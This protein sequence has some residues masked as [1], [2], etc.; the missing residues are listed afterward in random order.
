MKI[1]NKEL[2]RFSKQIILKNIGL[3]GQKKIFASKVLIIGVGGLG[4]PLAL[5]LA[6]SGVGNIGIIDHDKIELTNLNRQVLF[7]SKDLGKYKVDQARKVIKNIN[8][9]IK[10]TSYRKLVTKKNINSILKNYDIICDGTDNFKSRYLINDYC[11]KKKKILISAAISKYD[12]HIF[13]FNFKKKTPCFRCFMPQIPKNQY[14]CDTEGIISTLAGIMGT[15]QAN[16]VIK[17]I[18][19]SKSDLSGKM[20][21]FNSLSLDLRKVKLSSNTNCINECK[22]IK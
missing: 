21:V 13:K 9:K 1:A 14:N 4:C 20:I 18:I 3:S 12:G 15:M 22:K 17:S 8:K 6:N 19:N 16:E 2:K 5:Y 10:I 7:T 11:M